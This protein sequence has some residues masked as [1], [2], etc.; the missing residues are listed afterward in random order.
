MFWEL[1]IVSFAFC[2]GILLY[3]SFALCRM[4]YAFSDLNPE[5]QFISNLVDS[6]GV[7]SIF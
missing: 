6:F 2:S 1:E 5:F 4:L 7:N 3:L